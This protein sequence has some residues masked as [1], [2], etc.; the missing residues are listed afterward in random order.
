MES[1]GF[2][3]IFLCLCVHNC[4]CICVFMSMTIMIKGNN[5][6]FESEQA[7]RGIKG[8]GGF[9]VAF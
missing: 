5:Q 7:T 6:E 9:Y 8:E 3:C 4:V 2:L 1:V